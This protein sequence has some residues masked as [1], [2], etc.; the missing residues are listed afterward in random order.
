MIELKQLNKTYNINNHDFHALKNINLNIIR[1]E[2]FGVLGKSGAGKSTLLRCVNLLEKPSSG[3]VIINDIDLT[4][5]TTIALRQHRRRIGVV[6]QNFNLLESRTVFDNIA[7]P[8]EIIKKPKQEIQTKVTALLKLV[9]LK[10][11]TNHFPSQLSGG[12]KQKVAIARALAADPY[13]LLCD[14]ATSALD[15]ESTKSVLNLLK[16]INRELGLTILLITHELEVIKTICDRVGVIHNGELIEQDSAINVIVNPKSNITKQLV[17]QTPAFNALAHENKNSSILRLTF[18]GK[19]SDL[20]L[21]SSLVKK[22]DVSV[23]IREALIERIQNTTVGFTICEIAGE[24]AV[25]DAA[26]AFLRKTSIKIEVLS[27]AKL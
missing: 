12:Q 17:Q 1:G 22:F 5:L 14:E 26:L 10:D 16:S 27:H 2:I 7:L 19:D 20:P 4:S 24:Q 11:K 3:Q 9:S 8:L 23:N 15:T 21:I 13:V 25:L 6:F 18:I